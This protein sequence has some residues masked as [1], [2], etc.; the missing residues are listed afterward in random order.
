MESKISDI[1]ANVFGLN[2]NQVNVILTQLPDNTT[3]FTY[4]LSSVDHSDH[5]II[6]KSQFIYFK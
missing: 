6:N 4:T 3:N 1:I 2:K 5:N